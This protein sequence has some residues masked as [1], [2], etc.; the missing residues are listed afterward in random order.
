MTVTYETPSKALNAQIDMSDSVP[1]FVLGADHKS[2]RHQFANL[3]FARLT[4]LKSIVEEKARQ[5]WGGVKGKS[6]IRLRN[7][8]SVWSLRFTTARAAST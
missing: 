3:Y 1:S 6:V 2:Y 7:W 8:V 5:K 4:F